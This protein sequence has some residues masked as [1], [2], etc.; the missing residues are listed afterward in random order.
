MIRADCTAD[1]GAKCF[2]NPVS[3]NTRTEPTK[4][5]L[6]ARPIEARSLSPLGSAHLLLPPANRQLSPGEA[7]VGE[8]PEYPPPVLLVAYLRSMG[9]IPERPISLRSCRYATRE[10]P[11]RVRICSAAAEISEMTLPICLGLVSA[12]RAAPSRPR[13]ITPLDLLGRAIGQ[14]I[15]TGDG[16]MAP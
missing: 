10:S 9:G 6:T 5:H 12:V 3:P 7:T 16:L 13:A 11:G 14:D 4:A 15:G 2:A 8:T 1:D